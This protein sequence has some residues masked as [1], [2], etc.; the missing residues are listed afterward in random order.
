MFFK[1]KDNN[2]ENELSKVAA[3]LIYAAKIDQDF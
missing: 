2:K 3:L 1:S